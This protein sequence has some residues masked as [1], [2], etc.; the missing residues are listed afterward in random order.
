MQSRSH[1]IRLITPLALALPAIVGACGK[2]APN[3]T[4]PT[5]HLALIGGADHGGRPLATHMTQEVTSTPVWAGDPDGTGLA[6]I[7]LN[8]GTGEVCWQLGVSNITLPATGA[9]IHKAD[10]GVRGPIVV[11][12]S[13]PDASGAATGCASGVDRDL[14]LDI[15]IHPE[16]YYVN[17]HTTDF[18][19]GAV[20][21][22]LPGS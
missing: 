12:L 21:G 5:V 18:P 8:A 10:P 13:S 22:Q 16:S 3:P 20:R 4:Q 2:D 6:E 15:L 1:L 17:V 19:P 7:T 14:V 11:F 9:H